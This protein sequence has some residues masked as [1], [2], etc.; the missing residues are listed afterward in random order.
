[1]PSVLPVGLRNI[2]LLVAA[3]AP[4]S[5]CHALR[6]ENM[7]AGAHGGKVITSKQ[8][9]ESGATT[10]W[11][12]IRRNGTFFS[13][14]ENTAG[15]PTGLSRRGRGSMVLSENPLVVLDG[16]HTSDYTLLREIPAH[17]IESIRIFAGVEGTRYFGTGGGN[18]VILVRTRTSPKQ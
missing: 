18:G 12:A 9:Q 6:P 2:L 10:A 17:V 8:I 13:T 14:G 7:P 3:L 1:M 15:K 4:F 5:A 11:D 16:A